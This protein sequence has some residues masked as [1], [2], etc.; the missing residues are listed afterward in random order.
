MSSLFLFPFWIKHMANANNVQTAATIR[1]CDWDEWKTI[2]ADFWENISTKILTHMIVI[3]WCFLNGSYK[4]EQAFDSLPVGKPESSDSLSRL[5]SFFRFVSLFYVSLTLYR[6]PFAMHLNAWIRWHDAALCSVSQIC[7][8]SKAIQFIFTFKF[9]YL[10]VFSDFSLL[11]VLSCFY[12]VL[13][14]VQ[15]FVN[16]F[17]L[18]L[19]GK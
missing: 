6:Y 7:Q 10:R 8:K 12:L 3:R 17:K 5:L 2:W 16:V 4:W 13:I 15:T 11:I 18:F 1:V 14:C 9:Y 19:I